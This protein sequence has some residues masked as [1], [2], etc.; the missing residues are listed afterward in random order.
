MSLQVLWS[1]FLAHPAGAVNSLALF[2]AVAGA[3]LCLVTRV[4]E[5]RGL[6]RVLA[7]GELDVQDQD[8]RTLRINRF[9]Y[10][11]GAAC[12]GSALLLSWFSTRL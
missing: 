2:F 10:R 9:F 12:L 11:F 4:R 7:D 8:E 6:A 5:Q 3:W 1:L